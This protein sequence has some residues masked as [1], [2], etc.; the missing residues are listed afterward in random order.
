MR[1]N[2]LMTKKQATGRALLDYITRQGAGEGHGEKGTGGAAITVIIDE[3]TLVTGAH[4]D[5]ICEHPNGTPIPVSLAQELACHA[6]ITSVVHNR[7]D[8]AINAGRSTRYAT[9][10]QRAALESMYSTCFHTNCDEAI[11]NCHA[12][13]ITYWDHGGRTDLDNLLPTC[14]HHHRW[15]HAN[16]PTITLD[17]KRVATV[18]MPNGTITRHH[19]NRVPHRPRVAKTGDSSDESD[20]LLAS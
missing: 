11:T 2:K 12:H 10:S 15:I 19:P 17:D 5:T 13:H 20:S 14:Q 8:V 3:R 1:N 7:F 9:P 16:S 6:T 18:V 4:P